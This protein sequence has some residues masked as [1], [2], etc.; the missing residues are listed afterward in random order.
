MKVFYIVFALFIFYSL[1]EYYNLKVKH[2]SLREFEKFHEVPD[3]FKGKR[4]VF[5]SDLQFDHHLTCFDHLA[6]KKL[7]A[8]IE[9]Q[10]ADLLIIGGD[11]IHNHSDCNHFIFNYLK[12]LKMDKIAVLGNHD[13]RDLE[14]VLKGLDESNITLLKNESYMYHGINIY[15]CDDFRAGSPKEPSVQEDYSIV[16]SHNPDY[17]MQLKNL[18]IDLILSGHFHAGQITLFG[19]YAPAITSL[20]GQLFR[21]GVVK[22]DHTNVYVSSGVGGKVLIFPLRFFARPE[23]VLIEY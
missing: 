16:L 3:E 11:I 14:T 1:F 13:Y 15:G 5:I 4:I 6:A 18:N 9:K 12:D 10:K 22:L 21:Y 23:I 7:I 17:S 2:L 19:R 20:Y 8:L